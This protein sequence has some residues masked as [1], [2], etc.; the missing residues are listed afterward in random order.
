MQALTAR[1][2][3]ARS[4]PLPL[5]AMFG[6]SGMAMFAYSS[7]VFMAEI[8]AAFGWSRA[9]YSLIFTLMMLAG[10]VL[11]PAVGWLT[12][13]YGPRRIA[14]IGIVPFAFS[15]ALFG[16]ANGSIL[17]WYALGLLFAPFQAMIGVP[18]WIAA[19]VSRF[20]TSRGLAMAVGLAGLGLGSMVWPLLA[21]QFIPAFGWRP[22]FGLLA[23]CWTVPILPLALLFFYG[24]S[25]QAKGKRPV[26][27]KGAYGPALRSR[28]FIGLMVAGGLFMCGGFGITVHIVPILRGSGFS[29]T[30]AAA[31][32]G[33]IGACSFIGR[34]VTGYLLDRLPLRLV[35]ATAFSM[36]AL[37]SLLLL[38][39]PGSTVGAILAVALMGLS[40]GAELDIVAFIAARRFG[41]TVFAS[42][43]ALFTSITAAC[44]SFGPVMAGAIFDMQQSYD[45]YLLLVIPMMLASAGL[46]AWLPM[47]PEEAGRRAGEHAKPAG[48][49]PSAQ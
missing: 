49:Q 22:A 21:A 44:A 7:G 35:A 47:E 36:P 33:L 4:W 10:V 2:E 3:W 26:A 5:V 12:D 20:D 9:V 41:Q 28:T 48:A 45:L 15:F 6:V 14:L 30:S 23:L 42:I 8:T 43:Y 37:S 1:Q 11:L 17:Q 25:D 40:G 29:L 31:I 13:R 19:V 38:F 39:F 18:I 27:Q 34:L 24:A 16:L 46:I 32:A